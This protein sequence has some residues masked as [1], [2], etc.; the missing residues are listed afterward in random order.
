MRIDHDEASEHVEQDTENN[1]F[2]ELHLNGDA[3]FFHRERQS[4]RELCLIHRCQVFRIVVTNPI[5]TGLT[6]IDFAEK[7][8][9]AKVDL[10]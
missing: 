8:K 3:G 5:T 1:Y 7:R 10:L 9:I 2:H 6:C 4:T